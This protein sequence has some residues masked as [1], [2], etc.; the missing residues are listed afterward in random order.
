MTSREIA[1]SCILVGISIGSVFGIAIRTFIP[2]D[3]GVTIYE[4]RD[5]KKTCESALPRNVVCVP[6][7]VPKQ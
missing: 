3:T 1:I 2:L 5:M 7:F 4:L 6:A